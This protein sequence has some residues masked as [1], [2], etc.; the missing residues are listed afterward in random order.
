MTGDEAQ[1]EY[2]GFVFMSQCFPRLVSYASAMPPRI[3]WGGSVLAGHLVVAPVNDTSKSHAGDGKS[4]ERRCLAHH[5][6]L[7]KLSLS[8]S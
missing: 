3:Q 5:E 7:P 8:G 1:V 4:K 6:F 2:L